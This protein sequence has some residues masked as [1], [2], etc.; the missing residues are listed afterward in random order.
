MG[1]MQARSFAALFA[2]SLILA[3]CARW[4]PQHGPG[5]ARLSHA[6]PLQRAPLVA[7]FGETGVRAVYHF[8]AGGASR[9]ELGAFIHAADGTGFN[10]V[11]VMVEMNGRDTLIVRGAAILHDQRAVDREFAAACGFRQRHI[12]LSH[13]RHDPAVPGRDLRV[14]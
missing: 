7:G 6:C 12:Y 9:D 3:G 11:P 2:L 8:A 4:A 5:R 1:R 14:R 10:V 13:V